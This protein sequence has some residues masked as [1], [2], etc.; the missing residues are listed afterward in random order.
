MVV[1][2]PCLFLRFLRAKADCSWNCHSINT[3]VRVAVTGA[4]LCQLLDFEFKGENL[5]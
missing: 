5:A 3:V 2:T 1:W 4:L